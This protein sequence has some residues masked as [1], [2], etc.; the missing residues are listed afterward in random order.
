MAFFW[1][2][3]AKPVQLP[4]CGCNDASYTFLLLLLPKLDGFGG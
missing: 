1:V 2:L 4:L 3:G